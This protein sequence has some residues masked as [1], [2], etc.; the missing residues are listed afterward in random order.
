MSDKRPKYSPQQFF[1]P[2]KKIKKHT[3]EELRALYRKAAANT[4]LLQH[5]LEEAAEA[6]DGTDENGDSIKQNESESE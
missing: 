2:A 1:R 5:A 6:D 4:L 3:P